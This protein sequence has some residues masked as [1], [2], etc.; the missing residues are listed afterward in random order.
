M[1]GKEKCELLKSIRKNIAEMNGIEYYPEQCDHEGNCPG[2]CPRCDMEASYL[3]KELK[4]KEAAGSPIRIDTESLA[5]FETLSSEPV[6]EED[7]NC[8][9]GD[10]RTPGIIAPPEDWDRDI[11]PLQGDVAMP[12]DFDDD[13]DADSDDEKDVSEEETIDGEQLLE[14]N[15]KAIDCMCRGCSRFDTIIAT[16]NGI[17]CS[18]LSEHFFLGMLEK[19]SCSLKR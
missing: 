11:M 6:E 13:S 4:K 5:Q 1:T 2:F 19:K 12:D 18:C 3:M 10:I 14:D 8:I 15:R 7:D 16:D 17:R 9:V